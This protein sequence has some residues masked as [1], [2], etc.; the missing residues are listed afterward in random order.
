MGFLHEDITLANFGFLEEL[1]SGLF[2][3]KGLFGN[4]GFLSLLAGFPIEKEQD[5]PCNKFSQN[6]KYWNGK[7]FDH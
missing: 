1:S 4:F 2:L 3:V 5:I 7:S 6:T